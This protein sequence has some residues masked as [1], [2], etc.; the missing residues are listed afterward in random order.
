M[1]HIFALLFSL[2]LLSGVV[3]TGCTARPQPVSVPAAP[4]PQPSPPMWVGERAKVVVMGFGN[5]V[6]LDA[7]TKRAVADAVL[8]NSMKQHLVTGLHQTEQFAVL[9]QRGAKHTLTGQDFTAGG[10]IKRKA[11]EQIGSL[12]GAEFLIAGEVKVYQPS[13]TS[14]DAGIDADPFFASARMSG[15][16]VA[17]EA[18]T[19]AFASLPALSHD[20]IAISV[21][22]INA[23]NGKTIGLTT[24]EGTPQE[25]GRP[26]GG[27]FDEKLIRTSG[28]LH[29]PMQKALRVCTMKAV[30]WIA[31]TGL[32][33]RRQAALRPSSSP[34]AV[35]SPVPV[36]KTSVEKKNQREKPLPEPVVKKPG[37]KAKPTAEKSILETPSVERPSREKSIVE[38]PITG[39][40]LPKNEMPHREEWGQ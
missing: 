4:L 21:R 25:F 8:G 18:R 40:A 13:L 15:H 16:G 36:K 35:E 34:P 19:K 2:A 5:K 17:P 29:T 10:E 11:I 23:A 14:L 39:K 3:S 27:F 6:S 37:L 38:K 1:R 33:Y 22:L 28:S 31:E 26:G 9:H 20:R 30:N 24:V 12:D 7:R 32:A